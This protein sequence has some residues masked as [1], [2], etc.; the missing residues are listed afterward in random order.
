MDASSC[1]CCIMLYFA[2]KVL[3]GIS[4]NGVRGCENPINLAVFMINKS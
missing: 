4:F 3:N 2:E 1:P